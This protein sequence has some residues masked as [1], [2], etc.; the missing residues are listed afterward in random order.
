MRGKRILG[1]F[2]HPDDEAFGPGGSIAKWV[3]EGAEVYL[4]CA[5]KGEAGANAGKRDQ[6]LLEAAKV[7]GVKEVEFLGF[8]D[9]E[10]NNKDLQILEK[11]ITEKINDLKPDVLLTFDITGV[12]GHLDHI[13]VAS[14]TCQSFKN[15]DVVK[16][17]LLYAVLKEHTDLMGD[18]F[19]FRPDG[20]KK[21]EIDRVEDIAEVWDQK[22]EAMYKHKSQIEDIERVLKVRTK[23]P[24]EEY[25]IVRTK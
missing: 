13:A 22:L 10:I 19:I 12:S 2:A 6:E 23:L 17:L 15:T 5:T 1:I 4:L 8:I 21:E 9:G 20:R 3:K 11:V 16:Q 18:Y 25:F 24:K 14:A 7:L